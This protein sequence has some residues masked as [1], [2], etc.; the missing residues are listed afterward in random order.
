MSTDFDAI[1]IPLISAILLILAVLFLLLIGYTIYHRYTLSRAKDQLETSESYVQPLIY[2]FLDDE[3]TKK[4]FSDALKKKSD[5]IA[6]YRYINTMIDNMSGEEKDKLR[7][8]LGL[9]KFK[10]YFT[11]K[12]RTKS[13]VDLAQACMYFAQ[14]NIADFDSI[15]YLKP[16]QNHSYPVI[17]YA[18]TL[19]LINSTH[20]EV[21]DKALEIFVHRKTNASMAV[22]D[23]I[24]KYVENHKEKDTAARRLMK[25]ASGFYIP[26]KTA[27][28]IIRM[29]PELGFYQLTD[30]LF[31]EFKQPNRTD[32]SGM[33]T[34]TLIDVLHEFAHPE[35]GDEIIRKKLWKS[36]F[37]LMRKSVAFW[38]HDN[39]DEKYDDLIVALA[40]DSDLEV[41]IAAQMAMFNS[42]RTEFMEMKLNPEFQQE[43]EDIKKSGGAHVAT[44]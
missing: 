9:H 42:P 3:L 18:A 38:F 14:K 10:A 12:L 44:F 5:V 1:A 19:A 20:Q 11:K 40:S 33:Y 15:N 37:Q 24:F 2:Q 36:P 4:E 28:S 35:V 34:A 8:L 32:Y 43:W 22:T 30:D 6:A 27:V 26:A 31:K 39:F 16:L 29:F 17:A 7:D 25:Y 21:R 41:R 13:P 23:I